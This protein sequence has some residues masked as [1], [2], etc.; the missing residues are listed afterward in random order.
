VRD[1]DARVTKTGRSDESPEHSIQT[2]EEPM[3]APMVFPRRK[4]LTSSILAV[5][6]V[7]V[8]G[9]GASALSAFS[10]TGTKKRKVVVNSDAFPFS[11]HDTTERGLRRI[12]VVSASTERITPEDGASQFDAKA[13]LDRCTF[14]RFRVGW[15]ANGGRF[16][17]SNC[18]S[19]FSSAGE[20]RRGPA[21]RGLDSVLIKRISTGRWEVFPDEVIRGEAIHEAPS[22]EFGPRRFTFGDWDDVTFRLPLATSA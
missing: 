17:C 5:A 12:I 15:W 18:V 9:A 16:V 14:D 1:E 6:A 10:R 19:I 11:V 8:G 22:L 13:I 7:G 20:V 2:V 4:F 21:K 3:P